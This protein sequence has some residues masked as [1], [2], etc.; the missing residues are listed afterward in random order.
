M[1]G[2][3]PFFHAGVSEILQF[4]NNGKSFK[5]RVETDLAK[6]R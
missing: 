3:I 5:I 1:S 4:Y 6:E 2:V